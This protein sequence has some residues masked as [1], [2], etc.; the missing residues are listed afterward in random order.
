MAE[1]KKKE[2]KF[3]FGCLTLSLSHILVM[4]FTAGIMMLYWYVPAYVGSML[5][6]QIAAAAGLKGISGT[7]DDLGF[8]GAEYNDVR[9]NLG[10][11]RVISADSIKIDYQLPF[12]PFKREVKVKSITLFGARVKVIKDGDQWRVPGIYP[13]L[14]KKTPEQADKKP[15]KSWVKMEL[16]SI[17]LSRCS[18]QVEMGSEH[19]LEFPI[20]LK[21]KNPENWNGEIAATLKLQCAGDTIRGRLDWDR[22]KGNLSLKLKGVISPE[23]YFAEGSRPLS[24]KVA[25]TGEFFGNF[26][27]SGLDRLDG[28]V[29][30]NRLQL[31]SFGWELA[32]AGKNQPVELRFKQTDSH[33]VEYSLTGLILNGPVKMVWDRAAGQIVWR[34]GKIKIDGD[35]KGLFASGSRPGVAI[36]TPL[37]ITHRLDLDWDMNNARGDWKYGGS[38]EPPPNGVAAVDMAAGTLLPGKIALAATGA[39]GRNQNGKDFDLLSKTIITA[40]PVMVWATAGTPKV[41]VNAPRAEITFGQQQGKLQGG[42]LLTTGAV[43]VPGPKIRV[44]AS[45]VEMPLLTLARA[46]EKGR[47]QLR[48]V[49]WNRHPVMDVDVSVAATAAG[50]ALDGKL[51]QQVLPGAPWRLK[52]DMQLK[53]ELKGRAS[54]DFGPY[55]LTEPLEPGKYFPQLDGMRLSGNIE[56]HARFDFSP[57]GKTGS[58]AFQ[59]RDG[60]F[61]SEAQNLTAEGLAVALE[62]PSLP[63]MRTPPLQKLSCGTLQAGTVKLNNLL[64]QYQMEAGFALLLEN[65]SAEWCGGK[66]HTQSLR[67]APGQKDFRAVVYCDGLELPR[68]LNEMGIAK[69]VGSGRIHGRLPLNVGQDGIIL[70]PGFL[71]SEPGST[72]N[73]RLSGMEKMLEGMPAES[74]QYAQL[75]IASEALKD[76]NYE[77]VRINFANAGENLRLE[78]QI[79]GR[80]AQPLPFTYDSAKG[81]FVRVKG[82]KAVFQ[83]IRLDVNSNLPMNQLLKFNSNVK[84]LFGGNK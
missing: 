77:W 72:H 78:M 15:A 62:F 40:G 25:F 35:G 14:M 58:A 3:R 75:D 43:T 34:N 8:S 49:S 45:S 67:V 18:L 41:T 53:P 23:N 38:I 20:T 6:P 80:P 28:I 60:L 7:F 66:I 69:A 82:Q 21:I 44:D 32:N 46:G 74:A 10:G 59:L 30:L 70:E 39:V 42:I 48:Q 36:R 57:A 73:L 9:L 79:N 16:Q 11:S 27:A 52:L 84:K 71:Y 19:I 1:E 68:L 47:I 54:L 81:G 33:R 4:V 5:L 13:D 65:F 63:D 31:N 22:R 29:K 56:G 55:L 64:A 12:W 26:P 61:R 24:G 50:F 17:N 2:R 76:F 83:G 51:D 37:A